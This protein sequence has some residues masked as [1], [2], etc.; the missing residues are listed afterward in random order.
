M[1]STQRHEWNWQPP[2][3]GFA[4][5]TI[6][7]H[8]GGEPLRVITGALPPIEGR[9]VLEKRRYFREHY[10][11]LRSKRPVLLSITHKCHA[12]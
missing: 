3:N 12:E 2:A 9:T 5:S 1:K 4:I 7:L 8:T 10:D 11:H 6:D